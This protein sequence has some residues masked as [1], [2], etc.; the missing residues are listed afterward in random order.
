MFS[1]FA[2]FF[3]SKPASQHTVNVVRH[4]LPMDQSKI[5]NYFDKQDNEKAGLTIK[6]VKPS[7]QH[8]WNDVLTCDPPDLT[9]SDLRKI[10]LLTPDALKP[11]CGNQFLETWKQ[12]E[13]NEKV[14]KEEEAGGE[15]SGGSPS[16]STTPP[17]TTPKKANGK[18]PK[19]PKK[20]AKPCNGLKCKDNPNCLNHVG[21]SMWLEEDAFDSFRRVH[22]PEYNAADDAEARE[23]GEPVGLKN[24]GATCY[25]NTLL[26]VWFHNLSFREGVFAYT[27]TAEGTHDTPCDQL[28]K[29]FAHMQLGKQQF[30][31]PTSFVESLQIP[32]TEQQD[33]QEFAKLLSSLIETH[34]S[35]QPDSKVRNL[36]KD[37][38]EGHLNHITECKTCKEGSVR[39]DPFHEIELS[40]PQKTTLHSSLKRYLAE[41]LLDGDNQYFCERCNAKRDATRRI[42]LTQLPPVLTFHVMRFVFDFKTGAKKKNPHALEFPAEVDMAAYVKGG[43]DIDG[44]G[45]RSGGEGGGGGMMYDLRAVLL[46]RGKTANM[47]HYIARIWDETKQAWFNMDDET[48]ERMEKEGFELE[49][50]EKERKG[51]SEKKE[52][53]VKGEGGEGWDASLHSSRSAY[54]L[55]YVRRDA[56]RPTETPQPPDHLRAKVEE[57][58]TVYEAKVN[59]SDP[60]DRLEELRKTFDQK[61]HD[62]IDICTRWHVSSDD[63]PSYYIDTAALTQWSQADLIKPNDETKAM[64]WKAADLTLFDNKGIV[65]KHGRLSPVHVWRGKR[66]SQTAGDELLERMGCKMAP[67]LRTEDMCLLCVQD[68]LQSESNT[69]S[70]ESEVAFMKDQVGSKTAGGESRVWLSKRWWNDW[71]KKAS[72]FPR[73]IVPNPSDMPYREDVFCEH[74]GLQVDGDREAVEV[75]EEGYSFLRERF[76]EFETFR[77]D[78]A[79]CLTCERAGQEQYD[80]DS[81]YRASALEQRKTLPR[82]YAKKHPR[83]KV[84]DGDEYRLISTD[85]VDAWRVFVDRSSADNALTSIDNGPL[86]CEHGLMTYDVSQ[87]GEGLGEKA[88]LVN[89]EEWTAL[90]QWYRCEKPIKVNT[91]SPDY[92]ILGTDPGVCDACREV[93]LLDWKVS[94]RVVVSRKPKHDA[95]NGTKEDEKADHP[96]STNPVTEYT[97]RTSKRRAAAA[98]SSTPLRQSKRLKAKVDAAVVVRREWK[99]RDL[100]GAI[101]G[102][103]NIKPFLQRVWMERTGREL[104]DGEVLLETLRVRS[105]E[106]FLVEEVEAKDGEEEGAKEYGFAGTGLLRRHEPKNV[107]E[108]GTNGPTDMDIDTPSPHSSSTPR[109][110][111]ASSS[112]VWACGSCTMENSADKTRC[113]ACD[114]DRY[115]G[116]NC[117]SCTFLNAPGT[118]ECSMCSKEKEKG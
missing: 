87:N 31:D 30:Y 108:G 79:A 15:D 106:R 40:L 38:F 95:P 22:D 78:T 85:F 60:F 71:K 74:G 6:S 67:V 72:G 73:G 2:N 91:A 57:L 111:N 88:V 58:N 11:Y 41:E 44:G 76:P 16:A 77:L 117:G 7:L 51:K 98:P 39:S 84:V 96:G 3:M 103:F 99:V 83:T 100:K 33:S 8:L 109:P 116:W 48:V 9:E 68:V 42:E 55:V 49:E 89:Q 59:R 54:M 36:I 23:E 97:P 13:E 17:A 46:H 34:F 82:L 90:G 66:V 37:Q 81:G 75:S 21:A 94:T 56:P 50:L 25:L 28:Q 112:E 47:G 19:T 69:E 35:D 102:Q 107:D 113:G 10:Y 118:E 65:C 5:E 86:L 104:D 1:L 12:Q 45:G 61:R 110:P 115:P 32:K 53:K 52:E 29:A 101:S 80:A 27:P 70:H 63:E 43:I 14:K 24:L 26:Q 64:E 92:D 93:R 62:R 105:G 114:G 4:T 18:A 20:G